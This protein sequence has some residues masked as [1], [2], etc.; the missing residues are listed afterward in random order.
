[1]VA[2]GTRL[3]VSGRNEAGMEQV[4]TGPRDLGPLPTS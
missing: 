4:P 1:M 3:Y 2:E